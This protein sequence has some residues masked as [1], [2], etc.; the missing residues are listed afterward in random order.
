MF[1]GDDGLSVC[2]VMDN[3]WGDDDVIDVVMVM[4]CGWLFCECEMLEVLFEFLVG[5]CDLDGGDVWDGVNEG[6]DVAERRVAADAGS[7]EDE[8]EDGE[9]VFV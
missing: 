5:W 7:D 8:D 3:E 2:E 1:D 9:T 6:D 4:V